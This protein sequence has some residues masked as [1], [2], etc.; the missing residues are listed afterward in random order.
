[1]SEEMG[2]RLL[3]VPGDGGVAWDLTWHE[4][5][6]A[7]LDEIGLTCW[8]RKTSPQATIDQSGWTRRWGSK[9]Q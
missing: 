6:D 1:M 4:A 2:F 3:S 8:D 7:G 9:V 5:R